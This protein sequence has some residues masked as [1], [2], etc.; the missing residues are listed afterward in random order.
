M[1][2]SLY[3]VHQ[4]HT[5][6]MKVVCYNEFWMTN[7]VQRSGS[8]H[9]SCVSWWLLTMKPQ[10]Q[11][12]VTSCEIN[13]N[14]VA[15]ER[16][17][18]H[19]SLVILCYNIPPLFHTDYCCC[20][21]CPHWPTAAASSEQAALSL[22]PVLRLVDSSLTW[23]N[24]GNR[25]RKYFSSYFYLY[26][27]NQVWLCWGSGLKMMENIAHIMMLHSVSH[28]GNKFH[29]SEIIIWNNIQT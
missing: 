2:I 29:V 3:T 9:F 17:F 19:V 1:F 4:H 21:L 28:V 14:K 23:Q 16:S 27:G 12:Q 25:T 6:N 5:N 20:Q 15:L 22:H 26:T 7:S 11:Y 13:G 8:A 10:V 24:T 18:L